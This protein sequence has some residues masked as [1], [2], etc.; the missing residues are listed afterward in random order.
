MQSSITVYALQNYTFGS[1]DA[2]SDLDPILPSKQIDQ[3]Y[4][5]YSVK[6]MKT[7]VEAILIVH[8]H[9][10]P[11]LL[12]IQNAAG[13]L[14]LPHG[15]LLMGEDET[16]GLKRILNTLL[17]SKSAIDWDVGEIISVLYRP[18]FETHWVISF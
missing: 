8:D 13:Q 18:N 15:S 11:H 1:K 6:G 5:H 7:S 14:S 16:S 10:H 17:G 9:Q 12:M 2:S 4:Q 3:L